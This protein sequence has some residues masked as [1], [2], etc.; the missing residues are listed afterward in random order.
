[1]LKL[2]EGSKLVL[3]NICNAFQGSAVC[4]RL[5]EHIFFKCMDENRRSSCY[6][7]WYIFPIYIGLT[8][9]YPSFSL[10]PFYFS[11]KCATPMYGAKLK[12]Y[13]A[14]ST[15]C[16][17][18]KF[19]V[20]KIAKPNKNFPPPLLCHSFHLLDN[21][22][23]LLII[24]YFCT[25]NHTYLWTLHMTYYLW[26]TGKEKG[27]TPGSIQYSWLSSDEAP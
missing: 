20:E 22:L 18:T 12:K 25:I 26:R 1:M 10:P 5:T 13:Q 15:Q 7:I 27:K 21:L 16:C 14:A 17:H 4:A 19:T 6:H 3:K 11:W 8:F 23:I 9:C 2:V 24:K